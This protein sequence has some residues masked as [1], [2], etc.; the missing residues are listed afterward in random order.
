M[1]ITSVGYDGSINESQWARLIPLVGSSHYGV[2]GTGD[3]KV[4]SHPTMDRGVRIATGTGWGHGVMDTSDATV[5]LQGAS[6]GSG[7]RW[8]MVVAR[9]NWSG[10]G[11]NTTFILIGGSSSKALPSRNT[12]P[13]TLDD[14]PIALVQFTAG[15]TAPTQ[16]VDLR[17]WGRNGGMVVRDD[18][19]LG[20][21]KEPGTTVTVND[22]TWLCGF[23]AN[24]NASWILQ[25]DTTITQEGWVWLGGTNASG[26][27][28]YNFSTP[29]PNGVKSIQITDNNRV[30]SFLGIVHYKI[31]EGSVTKT[32]FK[33]RAYR[34]DGNALPNAGNLLVSLTA[35]GW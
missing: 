17:C 16:I 15:Q 2:A 7:T 19:A 25:T 22:L 26:D 9:R 6:L 23:D 34:G 11:G 14:Q 13:G 3:W 5:S 10:V 33:F 18:L 21:L 27:G 4:T 32:G 1:A 35:R 28:S 30:Y 31:I 29:F 12:S 8:D 20:Y 24:G